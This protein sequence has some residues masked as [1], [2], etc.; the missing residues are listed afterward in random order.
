MFTQANLLAILKAGW[1]IIVPL[2]ICSVFSGA[3]ILERW[4]TLGRAQFNRESLM[5]R[6]R[7]MLLENRREQAIAHCDSLNKPVGRV[8]AAILEGPTQHRAT[9]RE[10]LDR[11]GERLIRAEAAELGRY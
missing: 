11:L 6:L 9:T 4:W 7:R 3:I 2:L 5:G 8:V 1:A 10:Q